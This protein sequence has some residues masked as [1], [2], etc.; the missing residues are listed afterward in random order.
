MSYSIGELARMAG[1][2]VRTLHHYDAIGLLRP[3]ER[4]R[5]GYRRYSLRDAER[6]YRI[7]VYRE[8][9]L[10]LPGI[11]E[12]LDDRVDAVTQLE[13]Q[14]SLLRARIARLR[15]MLKGVEK[16]VESRKAGLSLT[17]EEMREVFGDFDPAAHEAEVEARWGD[18]DAYRESQRRTSKYDKAQWQVIQSE[19]EQITADF[20]AAL[21]RGVPADSP[22]A[23]DIAERHRQHIHRWFYECSH[24]MHRGLGE[25]YVSDP[26]FTKHYDDRAPGLAAYVRDAI[27]ANASRAGVE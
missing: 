4:T 7:L 2:S 16:M 3:M 18:T 1:V 9:G 24:A 12:I 27:I 21:A 11:A 20:A 25:M 26:R 10:D 8:I 15:R 5:S 19:A 14:R 17:P 22:E 23:M 6:L 13:R